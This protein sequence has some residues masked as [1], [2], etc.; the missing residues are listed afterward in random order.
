MLNQK[1]IEKVVF[2]DIEST[3]QHETFSAMPIRMQYLFKE[4]F[5]KEIKEE[6][7]SQ[8]HIENGLSIEKCVEEI[9]NSKAPLFAE[10]NKIVC[11]SMGII[12]TANKDSYSLKVK[13]FCGTDEKA[14]L[15]EFAQ[16]ASIKNYQTSTAAERFAFCAHNGKVF[17][18]PVIAKRMIYNGIDLPYIFDYTHLKPWEV[19]YLIDTKEAWKY[20][21]FDG[22]VSLDLLA[23]AFN[24]ESSKML[25]KGSDVK[26]VYYVTKDMAAIQKYCEH[27][28]FT[29]ASIYL[30]M[31]NIQV[32]LTR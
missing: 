11:I 17:D 25:M 31:K 9:Y 29:L 10:F 32:P 8:T 24:V 6:F 16:A 27:D 20:G 19:D 4:R 1:P 26:D 28:I 3:S 18:F 12:N 23:A 21:V 30:K 5:K 14:L 2:I 13:S 7:E 15:T 22:N